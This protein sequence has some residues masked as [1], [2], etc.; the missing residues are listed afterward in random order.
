MSR[1]DFFFTSSVNSFSFFYLLF[2][3]LFMWLYTVLQNFVLVQLIA[4][5]RWKD[6]KHTIHL[7]S[8]K[9]KKSI[10]LIKGHTTGVLLKA[11]S[12]DGTT[13]NEV[14]YKNNK[15]KTEKSSSCLLAQYFF[16]YFFCSS[17]WKKTHEHRIGN[18]TAQYVTLEKNTRYKRKP[19]S[20]APTA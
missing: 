5:K 19:K 10:K 3:F 4:W 14:N 2:T 7:Y 13:K 12:N 18:E 11:H 16:C 8:K 6:T 17:E 9:T 1:T 15:Q 20:K